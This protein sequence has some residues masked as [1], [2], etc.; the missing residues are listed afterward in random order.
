MADLLTQTIFPTKQK[1]VKQK[2]LQAEPKA[3]TNSLNQRELF[4]IKEI[5]DKE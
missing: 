5:N 4:H 3:K 2:G 1:Q